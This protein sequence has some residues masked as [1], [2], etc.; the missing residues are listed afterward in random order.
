MQVLTESS[1]HYLCVCISTITA[2]CEVY[3]L[4]SYSAV[5]DDMMALGKERPHS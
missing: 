5:A 2:T 3:R 4:Y 1:L